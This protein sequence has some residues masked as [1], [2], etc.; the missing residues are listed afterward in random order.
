MCVHTSCNASAFICVLSVVVTEKFQAGFQLSNFKLILSSMIRSVGRKVGQF[1]YYTHVSHHFPPHSFTA[2]WLIFVFGILFRLEKLCLV[3]DLPLLT[4]VDYAWAFDAKAYLSDFYSSILLHRRDVDGYQIGNGEFSPVSDPA[5]TM[6]LSVLP[7]IA[8][9]LSLKKAP[10]TGITRLLDIG[11]GP[12]IHMAVVFRDKVDEIYLSDYLE[13][14]CEQLRLWMQDRKPFDWRSVLGYIAQREGQATLSVEAMEVASRSKLRGVF[15]CDVFKP[16]VIDWPDYDGLG[17]DVVS[18]LFCLEF[19][20]NTVD[21]FTNA[22]TNVVRLVKPGGYLILGGVLGESWCK[23]GG[24]LFSSY[25]LT[26]AQL[27]ASLRQ[28]GISPT[29][30]TFTYYN[31]SDIFLVLAQPTQ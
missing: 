11:S 13:Q 12:T 16:G 3:N 10:E 4:R 1:Y 27:F 24:R 26:E 23:F 15:H 9:R 22:L 17:F 8:E 20:S 14:N 6:M 19:A 18:S 30:P 29:D 5:M 25:P 31:H 7:I 2:K 21:D 28:N